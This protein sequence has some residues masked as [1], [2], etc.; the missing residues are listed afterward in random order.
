M[1]TLQNIFFY[2]FLILG[3][4]TQANGI[5]YEDAE[6]GDASKWH[7]YDTT[8]SGAIIRNVYDGDKQS[9]VI[10][11]SGAKTANGYR[12]GHN[13]NSNKWDQRVNKIMKWS[14]KFNDHFVVYIS[15]QT[16]KGHRYVY[17]TAADKDKG[18]SGGYI[19]HG[20][21]ANIKDGTWHTFYRDIEADLKKYESDNELIAINAFLIRGSGFIDDIEI[22]DEMPEP[23]FAPSNVEKKFLSETT[24][25]LTWD[26]NS[27]NE[28][29][30]YL[31]QNNKL[32]TTLPQDTT[33]YQI[34]ISPT[35]SYKFYLIAFNDILYSKPSETVDIV[36]KRVVY[37]DAEQGDASK[38]HVYDT[39]PSGAIIRN[40]YDGDKQSN[41]IEFSGAKTA[42]GYRIG[43]NSNSNKWDQRVNKIMKWSLKFNDH[44][45]VYIST[46]TKKGHRY[47]YYTAAD[48][49][50]GLSGGYIHH[51]LG[52][53]IKDGTWHTFYRDIEADLKKY[54]SDNE[55]IAIN[56]FLIRGSGFIDDIEIVDEMPKPNS[57]PQITSPSTISVR[58]NAKIA[59]DIEAYDEDNDKLFY[60]ISAADADLLE[61]NNTTGLVTFKGVV[62]FELKPSYNFLVSVTDQIDTTTQEVTINIEKVRDLSVY[63]NLSYKMA[64]SIFKDKFIYGDGEKLNKVKIIQEPLEGNLTGPHSVLL[65][66]YSIS[67]DSSFPTSPPKPIDTLNPIFTPSNL[68]YLTYLAKQNYYGFDYIRWEGSMDDGQTW[69]EPMDLILF[70]KEFNDAPIFTTY[71]PSIIPIEKS[72][73]ENFVTFTAIDP[74]GLAISY[75]LGGVDAEL[76]QISENGEIS[77]LEKPRKKIFRINIIASDGVKETSRTLVIQINNNPPQINNTPLDFISMDGQF[78]LDINATDVDFETLEYSISGTDAEKFMILFQAT[79]E[80]IEPTTSTATL[81]INNLQTNLEE[82]PVLYPIDPVPTYSLE[83]LPTLVAKYTLPKGLHNITLTVSDGYDSV[84]KDITITVPYLSADKLLDDGFL[85]NSYQQEHRN[86]DKNIDVTQYKHFG[87]QTMMAVDNALYIGLSG[88]RANKNGA[89]VAKYTTDNKL[90]YISLLDEQGVAVFERYHDK[91][92]IPGTDPT[93]GDDWSFGNFYSLDTTTDEMQKFRNLPDTI[94]GWDLWADENNSILYYAGSERSGGNIFTSYDGGAN[95][96]KIADSSNGVG[97]YRTYGIVKINDILY[98][99]ES[100]GDL[101][102]IKSTDEGSTWE[103]VSSEPTSVLNDLSSL[104]LNKI[105]KYLVMIHNNKKQLIVVDPSNE[106]KTITYTF[107]DGIYGYNNIT[108]DGNGNIYIVTNKGNLFHTL[109]YKKWT[110][111]TRVP[112]LSQ[113]LSTITYWKDQRSLMLGN[114]DTNS[115]KSQANLWQVK[116]LDE[117]NNTIPDIFE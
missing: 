23:V 42:N 99:I 86:N 29:G 60:E 16:K 58:A 68:T 90:S 112:N 12:I 54:E 50:K 94:H 39:T 79:Y 93:Y 114:W 81:Q 100:S 75:S 80:Y 108:H 69:S 13:S 2:T 38:W 33:S 49:D 27:N 97:R 117:N 63:D 20:L 51:G 76:F 40:V 28:T 72:S 46:Q 8:P 59:I 9:N 113:G 31:Y 10:E 55:L 22:V 5:V 64:T 66:S 21:G 110:L 85:A 111:I 78:T 43:H 47:V 19:H 98:A 92:V 74:E 26:D 101:S 115:D 44:F 3:F 34:D 65:S 67:I 45:V 73:I 103:K 106:D 1:G 35:S 18:L 14:L 56:A 52:A 105:D 11:F 61:I 71:I 116:V 17:Y 62:D 104:M 102:L 32:L 84:S 48:K 88:W 4:C 77:F 96:N 41:V 57:A 30:F 95:W 7:V 82:N 107:Q 25:E 24:L 109:D 53:N 37:E 89:A 15:T 36:P 91:L 6:Q 87:V 70:V 83:F